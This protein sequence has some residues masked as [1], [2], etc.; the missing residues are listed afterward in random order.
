M[1]LRFSYDFLNFC[2]NKLAETGYPVFIETAF[3]YLQCV[4]WF[5]HY[6]VFQCLIFFN[7]W[8]SKKS[9][10]L[11]LRACKKWA[12]IN[13]WHVKRGTVELEPCDFLNIF[14]K[15]WLFEPHF[16]INFFLIKKTCKILWTEEQL[17]A[18]RMRVGWFPA[19]SLSYSCAIEA[20]IGWLQ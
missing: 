17:W 12:N 6:F 9:L 5:F 16:L 1:R 8:L 7:P 3:Y 10:D 4:E 15:F 19:R 13:F 18:N 14:L 11:C 2:W 20:N